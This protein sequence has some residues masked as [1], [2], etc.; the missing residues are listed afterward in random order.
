MRKYLILILFILFS[1]LSMAQQKRVFLNKNGERTTDSIGANSYYTISQPA[2]DSMWV[3]HQYNLNNEIMTIGHFRDT[4]LTILNGRF[5]YY[6]T[7]LAEQ[8]ITYNYTNE[9]YDTVKTAQRN[10]IAEVG[11]YVDG[12]KD[13]KWVGYF[14]N[15]SIKRMD[16]YSNG[17]SDGISTV[18]FNEGNI[19][20]ITGQYVNGKREGLWYTLT[21]KG[22]TMEVNTYKDGVHKKSVSYLEKIKRAEQ[23]SGGHADFDIVDYINQKLKKQNLKPITAGKYSFI[24]TKEGK[25]T[26]PVIEIVN[27]LQFDKTV[28]KILLDGPSW[29]P[30]FRKT[31]YVKARVTVIIMSNLAPNDN[32][33]VLSY[34]DYKEL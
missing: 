20:S 33:K 17:I 22:D 18:Y 2:P 34:Y 27:D 15:G 30:V 8:K 26:E 3:V 11:N 32:S 12:K 9:R 13:G 29:K 25:L 21:Y 7:Q 19:P 23:T 14:E 28:I 6:Q 24:V 10:Y 1:I 31:N 5:V 16:N 4:L